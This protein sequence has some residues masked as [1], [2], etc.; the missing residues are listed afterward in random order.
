MTDDELGAARERAIQR[1][2]RAAAILSMPYGPEKDRAIA[3]MYDE[4]SKPRT[5]SLPYLTA[6]G[7]E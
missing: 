7:D 2:D 1:L 6:G 3:A 5:W 4:L